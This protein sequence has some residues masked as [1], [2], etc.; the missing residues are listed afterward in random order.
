MEGEDYIKVLYIEDDED[1]SVL[2]IDVLLSIPF[3]S[4]KVTHEKNLT[5]GLKT[6]SD[7]EFDLVMLDLGLPESQG[8]ETLQN[9]LSHCNYI[10]V[11]VLT[12]SSDFKLG[13]DAIKAGAADFLSKSEISP[14]S[15][16]RVVHHSM[17]RFEILNDLEKK[18]ESLNT[19]VVAA[20]HDVKK[21][22]FDILKTI[23]SAVV[24]FRDKLPEE[25][26]LSLAQVRF[27]TSN[28]ANLINSLLEF[29]K[30]EAKLPSS[31]HF[32]VD[33]CISEAIEIHKLGGGMEKTKLT[34][35]E[36]LPRIYGNSDLLTQV[37]YNLMGNAIKF[38]DKK[39]PEIHIGYND[40]EYEHVFHVKDNGIGIAKENFTEIFE[41]LKR[42]KTE[43]RYPG[44]GIGLS[45]CKRIVVAHGGRIWLESTPGSGS[46]FYF[47]LP[48]LN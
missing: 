39:S 44:N 31:G 17:E 33:A 9:V 1:H 23:D 34:V 35:Q 19:F 15:I 38:V 7:G 30:A 47:S 2:F 11:V 24:K 8:L 20:S 22:L 18:N 16:A 29:S 40:L 48:K 37:F 21:P 6:L 32:L 5:N 46:T 36:H 13:I 3:H 43:K 4:Y 14:T 42:L 10:P 25:L 12:S 27:A 28:V 26:K 41:P 45:I